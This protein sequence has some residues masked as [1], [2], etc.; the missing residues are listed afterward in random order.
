MMMIYH[1]AF[2]S[3]SLSFSTTSLH[4]Q[5]QQQYHQQQ[6]VATIAENI[7]TTLFNPPLGDG[8]DNHSTNPSLSGA[9][10]TTC[11]TIIIIMLS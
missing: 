5:Q 6:Q 11:I 8:G 9:T 1:R 4:H 3:S 7:P 10:I 2:E